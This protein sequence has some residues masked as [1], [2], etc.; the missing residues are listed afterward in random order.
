MRNTHNLLL[1]YV[2]RAA[3]RYQGPYQCDE[4]TGKVI[5]NPALA[6]VIKS[7][8]TVV[9]NK[10]ATDGATRNHAEPLTIED[11]REIMDWSQK[12]IP[13]S[14]AEEELAQPVVE[15]LDVRDTQT[16]FYMR[17]FLA[18]GFILWTRWEKKDLP[19]F[20]PFPS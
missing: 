5:G 20:P 2:C 4:E 15:G 11:M 10:C 18:R 8:K 3:E 13:V 14:V 9:K 12:L 7:I 17:A 6:S 16:H 19:P 1:P